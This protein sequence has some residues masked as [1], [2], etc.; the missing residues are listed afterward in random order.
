MVGAVAP[1]TDSDAVARLTQE[2]QELERMLGEL[3][4]QVSEPEQG[5]E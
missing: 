2:K 4:S 5:K 3:K 1:Q